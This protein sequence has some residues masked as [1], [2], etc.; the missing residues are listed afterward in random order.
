MLDEEYFVDSL[1]LQ[2]DTPEG[3]P[4]DNIK[5]NMS[6]TTPV[7]DFQAEN[8]PTYSEILTIDFLKN[9]DFVQLN[10]CRIT[11][12]I[13]DESNIPL[14]DNPANISEEI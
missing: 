7:L 6:V 13:F 3:I 2:L 10:T 12:N 14:F 4:L 11:K 5:D 9:L 1:I 8:R